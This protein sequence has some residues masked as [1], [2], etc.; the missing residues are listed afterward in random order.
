MK[1]FKISPHFSFY[2]CTKTDLLHLLDDNRGQGFCFLDS[3]S[4][5][6]SFLAEP[7]RNHFN[8][9]LI[10]HSLFRNA[11]INKKIG[12][13]K[14][15]QHLKGEAIDFHVDRID[16][17]D[18]FIWIVKDSGLQFGQLILEPSW[19]HISQGYPLRERERCGEVG[20]WTPNG[21]KLVL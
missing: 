19:I 3:I 2:E 18:V 15:S 11:E 12:G 7:I 16:N 10:V 20:I 13:S 9:P 4:D 6:V 8:N 21:V 14:S 5:L 17:I 1:D